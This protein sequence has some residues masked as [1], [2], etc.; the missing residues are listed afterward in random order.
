MFAI[1]IA[2]LIFV[3]VVT[4][5]Y[6]AQQRNNDESS[7]VKF[8]H[9]NHGS[10]VA[11]GKECAQIGMSILK[12]GG[13]VADAAI[14]TILCEGITCKRETQSEIDKLFI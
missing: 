4:I 9:H 2:I 3:G 8:T 14:S 12:K 5:Y 1:F 10:V 6:L 7:K 13:T 11:N